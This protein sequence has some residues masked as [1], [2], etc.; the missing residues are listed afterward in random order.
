MMIIIWFYLF[1]AGFINVSDWCRIMES[2][3]QLGLPWRLLRDK[4]VVLDA[5]T[6]LVKYNTTFDKLNDSDIH[7]S[8]TI[9]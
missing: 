6:G 9:Y 5:E 1:S 4:L 3:T 8:R 7:V 2:A